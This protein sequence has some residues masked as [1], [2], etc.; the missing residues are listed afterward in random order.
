MGF[1]RI[2]V[3]KQV[4]LHL[5]D[6][7]AALAVVNQVRECIAERG[8]WYRLMYVWITAEGQ[9]VAS[10]YKRD[11]TLGNGAQLGTVTYRRG[12][13]VKQVELHG[14]LLGDLADEL[15]EAFG[16]VGLSAVHQPETD[17]TRAAS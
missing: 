9:L 6:P 1:R 13:R 7:G 3:A 4:M 10:T 11:L 16:Q 15:I 5:L 2:I 12:R 8:R 17:P 14:L